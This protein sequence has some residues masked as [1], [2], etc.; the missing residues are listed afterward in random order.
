MK[1]RAEMASPPLLRQDDTPRRQKH[2]GP[3]ST[4]YIYGIVPD[5]ERF[6]GRKR[7]KQTVQ[8]MINLSSSDIP[9]SIQLD[10]SVNGF[11]L[12]SFE[13]APS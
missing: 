7:I 11:S 3:E 4:P 13:Q 5:N 10:D 8:L 12:A 1:R 9:Y 2:S 6:P